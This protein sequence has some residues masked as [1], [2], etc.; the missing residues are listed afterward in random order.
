MID[1]LEDGIS[2]VALIDSLGGDLTVANAAR[3]SLHK[4]HPEFTSGDAKLIQYLAEHG[5]WC[6]DEKTEVL[7]DNDWKLFKDLTSD[8]LVA[9]VWPTSQSMAFIKPQEIHDNEYTGP[10][11]EHRSSTVNYLVTPGHKFY[12]NQRRG[13]VR[14][15]GEAVNID[16]I[17]SVGLVERQWVTIGLDLR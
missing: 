2:S 10:M 12:V 4:F 17:Y 6:Y 7:T 13:D 1:P 15:T 5:H 16:E 3:V 8:D 14:K 11:Y 9:Q